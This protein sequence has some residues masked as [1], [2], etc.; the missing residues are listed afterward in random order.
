VVAGVK[1]DNPVLKMFGDFKRDAL[2]VAVLGRNQPGA[3]KIY[4]RAGWK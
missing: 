3:Q 4:D 2:N 1:P